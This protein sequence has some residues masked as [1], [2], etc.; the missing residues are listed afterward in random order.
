MRALTLRRSYTTTKMVYA[1]QVRQRAASMTPDEL[2]RAC[3]FHRL[4]ARVLAK[5]LK[6]RC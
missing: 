2:K 6:A 5:A 4:S 3:R 1:D